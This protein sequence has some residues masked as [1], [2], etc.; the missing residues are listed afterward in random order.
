MQPIA[1]EPPSDHLSCGPP[2]NS[3]VEFY[4]TIAPFY[5][6]IYGAI[7]A[8]ETVR[9]WLL[10]LEDLGLVPLRQR[11]ENARSRLVDVGCGPGWHLAAWHG[12][13]FEVAG[14][15]ASPSMLQLAERNFRDAVGQGC[16]LFL[17]DIRCVDSLPSI[18]PVD[19]AVS[20]F[21]F[22]NLF[23]PEEREAVF[24]G[25]A[26]LVRLGGVWM[27][28]FPEPLRPPNQIRQTIDLGPEVDV[29]VQTGCF[30]PALQCYEQ[31]LAGADVDTTEVYWFNCSNQLKGLAERTGWRFV[32]RCRWTPRRRR[33]Q[34]AEAETLVDVYQRI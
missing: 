8:P 28:D 14:L 7:D 13:G 10:L 17:A 24:N 31:R 22:L 12:A 21:N 29:L 11:R 34:N 5:E 15:D 3:N 20:H 27:T 18:E 2:R 25:V 9:Q 1:G 33:A 26:K 19:V 6:A 30:D 23:R 4:E 32:R 16:P